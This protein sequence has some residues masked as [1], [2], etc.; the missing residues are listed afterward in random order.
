VNNQVESRYRDARRNVEINVGKACNNK[1]VFCLDGMPKKEDQRFMDFGEMKT[2]LARWRAEGHESVGFLGGEPT[3]Y[4]K[5][6]ESIAYARELGYTRIALATNAMMFRRASFCDRLVD[7]G[8]SRVTISMHGHTRALEDRLT[9]VPGAFDKKC[10]AIENLKARRARGALR[11]G[12]SVNIVLNGWNYQKLPKMMRFFYETLGLDDLRVNFVR[13]EGY[14]EGNADLTPTLTEV[15]P[16]LMKAILLNEYHFRKTFTF[17][18][19]PLCVLPDELRNSKRLLAEYC[20]DIYRDLSTDCSIRSDGGP[21]GVSRVENGRA[22]FN[23]QDRKRFDLKDHLEPCR[24]C[25]LSDVC[26]GVWRG[27]LDIYGAS[28]LST[29]LRETGRYER[30]RPLPPAPRPLKLAT[31]RGSGASASTS[32][33]IE[34]ASP[35]GDSGDPVPSG[36][37]RLPVLAS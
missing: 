2:E 5:I 3:M 27:Y 7:A 31:T 17:G 4:P 8:L 37:R 11:D 22:R 6:A 1:C 13:P 20:G 26:E 21:E 28:E 16:I 15:M 19:V 29:L 32:A 10:A 18:G 34:P 12:L 36:L 35:R 25:A 24:P 30:A 33:R 23:W 9:D 14:A